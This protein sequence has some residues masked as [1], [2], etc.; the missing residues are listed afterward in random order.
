LI[1]QHHPQFSPPAIAH[2]TLSSKAIDST[3]ALFT[4]LQQTLHKER[5]NQTKLPDLAQISGHPPVNCSRK[6]TSTVV[7]PQKM[8]GS[9]YWSIGSNLTPLSAFCDR[10]NGSRYP[11]SQSHW[12]C[13]SNA[14]NRP[15]TFLLK[16]TDKV[17]LD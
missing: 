7:K 11:S 6:Q 2:K 4:K 10:F 16:I 17:G 5:F 1:L 15:K 8:L 13:V 9:L 14:K 12:I 3:T